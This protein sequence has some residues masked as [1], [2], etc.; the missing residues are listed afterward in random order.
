MIVNPRY[1]TILGG[2]PLKNAHWE[3][4]I[5]GLILVIVGGVLIVQ[6]TPGVPKNSTE[7][8]GT[9]YSWV[10]T[11]DKNNS[12]THNELQLAEKPGIVYTIDKSVLHPNLPNDQDIIK[13][14]LLKKVNI[15]TANGTTN[16]LAIQIYDPSSHMY[17]T[18]HTSGGLQD[19]MT[20]SGIIGIILLP[21][22]I[23]LLAIGVVRL[24]IPRKRLHIIDLRPVAASEKIIPSANH[25]SP[26]P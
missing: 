4:I 5:S 11:N 16:V 8:D 20:G 21:I 18:A 3:F 25:L 10:A 13:H 14:A 17:T 23:I 6:V 2:Y 7:I 12:Y 9:L 22:S 19:R 15:W 1:C 26:R 24:R